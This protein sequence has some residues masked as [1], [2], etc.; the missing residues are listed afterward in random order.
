M[1]EYSNTNIADSS[2]EE[3]DLAKLFKILIRGKLTIISFTTFCD[4][5]CNL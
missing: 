1:T 3:I 4:C 2:V 5:S